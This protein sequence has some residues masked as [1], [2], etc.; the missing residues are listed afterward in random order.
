M[1]RIGALLAGAMMLFG[2]PAVAEAKR[3]SDPEA[4]QSSID[5]CNQRENS[6]N[7]GYVLIGDP[8]DPNPRDSDNDGTAMRIGR[9]RG[10]ANAAENSPALRACEPEDGGPTPDPDPF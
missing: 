3:H 2:A 1:R 7:G 6:H 9:G 5:V 10:V 4:S 8:V